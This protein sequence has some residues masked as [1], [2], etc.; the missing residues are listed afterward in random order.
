MGIFFNLILLCTNRSE[1][2]FFSHD[3]SAPLSLAILFTVLMQTSDGNAR[4]SVSLSEKMRVSH[5]HTLKII[6][7]E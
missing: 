4:P 7:H 2:L 5:L 3:R 1:D 6:F